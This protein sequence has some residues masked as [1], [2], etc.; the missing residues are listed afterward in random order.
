MFRDLLSANYRSSKESKQRKRMAVKKATVGKLDDVAL[1]SLKSM[2]HS[3]LESYIDEPLQC[4]ED[5]SCYRRLEEIPRYQE[6]SG[7]DSNTEEDGGT[8]G[9]L[10]RVFKASS[11]DKQ[12]NPFEPTPLA[13][14]ESLEPTLPYPILEPEQR[15]GLPNFQT[16]L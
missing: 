10:F 9:I 13:E 1:P 5:A 12:D 8:F 15:M 16:F 11:Y 7:C 3:V 14:T 6:S 4:P 2:A